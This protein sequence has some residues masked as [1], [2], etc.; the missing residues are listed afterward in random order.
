M[1]MTNSLRKKLI[2]AA[3]GGAMLI[4][5]AFLGD[6]DSVEGRKYEAY[7]DVTGV[8]TVCD[9]HTGRDIVRNKTYTDRECDALLWKDL[10]PA[11]CTVDQ[12]VKV[13]ILGFAR[14]SGYRR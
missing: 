2:A 10:Q 4:A 12:L 11:K 14:L 13:P 7:K 3:G 1:P 9:G 8:W 5:T 6:H